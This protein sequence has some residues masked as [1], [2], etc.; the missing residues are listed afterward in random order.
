MIVT[1]VAVSVHRVHD[2]LATTRQL[3][4]HEQVGAPRERRG[5]VDTLALPARQL[6][7]RRVG[8][9]VG[10]H[11]FQARLHEVAVGAGD[12]PEQSP[13]GEAPHRDHVAHPDRQGEP[14]RPHL[15]EVGDTAR[16]GP[17][18]PPSTPTTPPTGGSSPTSVDLLEPL[19]P[20]TARVPRGSSARSMP[21]TT[22]WPS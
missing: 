2:E 14:R 11:P 3:A 1:L 7:E 12:P 22:A 8:E 20:S 17:G 10:A 15:P 19:V 6:D 5:D 18:A 21:V 16:R 9:V 13:F 4:E